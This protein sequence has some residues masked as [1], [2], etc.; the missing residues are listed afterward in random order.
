[1]AQTSQLEYADNM[2]STKGFRHQQAPSLLWCLRKI[3]LRRNQLLG[4]LLILTFCYFLVRLDP[5]DYPLS[6]LDLESYLV[7]TNHCKIVDLDP[8]D[9]EVMRHFKRVTYKPCKSHPPL[10]TIHYNETTKR[11]VLNINASAPTESMSCCYMGVER[12]SET[13]V[14]YT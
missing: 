5:E 10:T 12:V 3:V 13:D 1:M 2:E 6:D 8:D 9:P 7:Y 14:S 4:L 11:Y